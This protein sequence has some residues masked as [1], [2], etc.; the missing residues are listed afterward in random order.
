MLMMGFAIVRVK[1]RPKVF[2]RRLSGG[3]LNVDWN[4]ISRRREL[5]TARMIGGGED[6]PEQKF[7]F[8]GYM[9]RPR[10]AKDPEG[11][12]LSVSI[13]PSAGSGEVNAGDDEAMALASANGQIFWMN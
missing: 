11:S 4:F 10:G 2:G 8:L 5:S 6:Y 9:F 7:D 3:L 13:R 1:P 12:T